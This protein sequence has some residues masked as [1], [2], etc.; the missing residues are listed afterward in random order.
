LVEE[1]SLKAVK[2]PWGLPARTIQEKVRKMG[3]MFS[4]P[5]YSLSL[6]AFLMVQQ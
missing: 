2:C 3:F 5:V 1:D 6:E 4:I